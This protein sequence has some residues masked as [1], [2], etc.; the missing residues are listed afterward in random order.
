MAIT[1]T[2]DADNKWYTYVDWSTWVTDQAK[3][4][5]NGPELTITV[6]SASWSIPAAL[7]QEAETLLV[8]NIAYFVGS[9]GA[10]GTSYDL[11]CTITY[12]AAELLATDLT[13]DQTITVSLKDQ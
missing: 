9:S 6:T 4:S 7:V 3:P 11:V 5:P 2:R 13:Q 8:G 1:V 12:S 10:N